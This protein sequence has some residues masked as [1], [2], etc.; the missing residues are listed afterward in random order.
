MA[1]CPR[2]LLAAAISGFLTAGLAQPAD[3]QAF[4]PL[5]GRGASA[6]A[7]PAS[8]SGQ[9]V[10][11]TSGRGVAGA[12]VRIGPALRTMGSSGTWEPNLDAYTSGMRYVL[13][14][15]DGRFTIRNIL[16]ATYL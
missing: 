11:G 6:G 10:D 15:G 8:S 13:A 12:I 5:V 16:P 2:P 14:D 9:V 4:P 7:A 3:A 1:R